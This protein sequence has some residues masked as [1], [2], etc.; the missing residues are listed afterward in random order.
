[1]LPKTGFL[2]IKDLLG[3]RKANPPIA[4][5]IPVGKSTV[6]SWV[7]SGKFPQ[8]VKLGNRITVWR[9]ED[10]AKFL[11]QGSSDAA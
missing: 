9:A 8:P 11:E 10:I 2:R 7:K 4:P 3:D 6:W 1:M 5:I